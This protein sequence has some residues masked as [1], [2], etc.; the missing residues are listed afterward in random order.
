MS[1]SADGGVVQW[2]C[3]TGQQVNSLPPHTLGVVSLSVSK[4][5]ELALLNTIE[6]LTRL[7]HLTE[8]KVIGTHESF[9]RDSGNQTEPGEYSLARVYDL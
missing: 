4:N 1:A 7:W 6:G 2:D 8:N 3:Q 5:G 9:A